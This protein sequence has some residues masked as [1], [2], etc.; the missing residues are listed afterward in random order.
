MKIAKEFTWEMGHRLPAHDGKCKNL[1]GHSYKMLVEFTGTIEPDGMVLD[2]YNVKE[3]I[4]PLVD[5]LDH[6]FFVNSSDKP[7]IAALESLNS[8]HVVVDF[9]ATAENLCGYFLEKIKNANLP[10]N[11]SAI[12]VR[13][14][15]TATSYAEE[16]VTL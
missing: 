2:Y 4:G 12:K 3:I 11:I 1:H 14:F 5:E 15:E 8:N 9:E 6:A 16:E 13:V 10:K 7:L